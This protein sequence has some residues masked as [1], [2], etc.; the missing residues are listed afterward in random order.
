[1]KNDITALLAADHALLTE[2][3]TDLHAAPH[4]ATARLL[5]RHFAAA[6]G[7][8]LTGVRKV[9]YPSLKAVGW[10][11]VPSDLLLGHAQLTHAFAELLTLAHDSGEFADA[12]ADLLEG[13]AQLI[14]QERTQLLPLLDQHLDASQRL[15]LHLEAAPYFAHTQADPHRLRLHATD[16]LEEARLLLGAGDRLPSAS[17]S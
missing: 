15:G 17:T 7:G 1:M 11:D 13:T 8:H 10:K 4:P 6:L 3:A 9:V 14:E 16:W 2:L 12:L 5:F